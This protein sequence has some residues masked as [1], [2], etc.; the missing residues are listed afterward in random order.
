M[1]G[2]G[3]TGSGGESLE[4]HARGLFT[5]LV[6]NGQ[7][8]RI[9]S[10]LRVWRGQREELE[11]NIPLMWSSRMTLGLL[12]Y[13][14]LHTCVPNSIYPIC[15]NIQIEITVMPFLYSNLYCPGLYYL[16]LPI[17]TDVY[18]IFTVYLGS[19]SSVS[20]QPHILATRSIKNDRPSDSNLIDLSSIEYIIYC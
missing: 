6:K 12:R 17:S 7:I 16:S 14:Q 5:N 10:R 2:K 3:S 13:I 11:I 1:V 19:S 4:D 15:N 9:E 20:N 18:Y 8:G